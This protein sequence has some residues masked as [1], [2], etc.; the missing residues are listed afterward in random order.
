MSSLVGLILP[1]F[2]RIAQPYNHPDV[3]VFSWSMLAHV[4]DVDDKY[5]TWNSWESTEDADNY[6]N[7]AVFDKLLDYLLVSGINGGVLE[8]DPIA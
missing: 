4:Q 3:K 8:Y 6:L 7:S 2:E 1:P 5:Y